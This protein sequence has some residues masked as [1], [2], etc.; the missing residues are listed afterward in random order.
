MPSL[1]VVICSALWFDLLSWPQPQ[2]F[3]RVQN[4]KFHDS[5]DV[6]TSCGEVGEGAE[7]AQCRLRAVQQMSQPCRH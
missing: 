3:E 1:F 4:I 5:V 7:G 6:S 2:Y